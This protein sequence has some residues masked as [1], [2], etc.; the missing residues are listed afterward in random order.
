MIALLA[1]LISILS[2]EV[3]FRYTIMK[4]KAIS[5][6]AVIANAWHHRSDALSSIGTLAGIG[7]A[8]FLGEKWRVLDPIAAFVVSIFIMKVS[9][10][11]LKPCIDELLEKSLPKDVEDRIIEIILSHPEAKSPH[12]LRT[13]NL[14]NKIAIEFHVRVNPEM[15]IR[16][17]HEVTKH[18]EKSLKDEFGDD[19]HIGIHIEPIK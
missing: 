2:K 6:Q 13:R 8:M 17:G 5:S 3:L 4:G 7:G 9:I 10:E 12:H 15:T 19:T 16:D 1:A 11:L 14:G 18:I